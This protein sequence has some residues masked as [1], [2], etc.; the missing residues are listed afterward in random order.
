MKHITFISLFI[1]VGYSLLNAQSDCSQ[2][3]IQAERAYYTGRFSEVQTI[4]AGC[5]NYGATPDTARFPLTVHGFVK[6]QKTE[7]YK[8][9]ALSQIFSR[10]FTK[11][12]SALLLMLKSNP[13]Y[14]FAAQDPPELRKRIERFNVH[15]LFEVSANV[16]LLQPFFKVNHIYNARALPATVIYH[17]NTG[18]HFGLN[19]AYYLNKNISLRAGYEWQRYSFEI[20]NRDSLGTGLFTEKQTRSQY[21][22]SLGYSFNFLKFNFQLYGGMV[23]S[24]LQ[25]SNGYLLLD[26]L[27]ATDAV[28]YDYSNL[29]QRSANEIRP[30]VEL[31]LNL[32]QK[33]KW[34]ISLSLRYEHGIKNM[35]NAANRYQDLYKAATLEW[36][37]DDFRGRNLIFQFSVAKLFYR[38]KL[39]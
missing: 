7:A 32:P 18:A 2:A 15:P 29:S 19:G 4:L 38:I 35:T 25:K 24:S 30:I 14:E 26:R 10:N 33:N 34:L 27:N 17:G 3:L 9:I 12:D 5:L 39:K 6:D 16:G 37:E 23:Y 11:A 20:E 36:V 13:Q 28:A 22:L 1:L 8:L 31:K 21:Q